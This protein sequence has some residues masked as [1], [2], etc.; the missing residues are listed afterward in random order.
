MTLPTST[1]L[2]LDPP[3]AYAAPLSTA[4]FKRRPEDFRVE[5]ILGFAA[6]GGEGHVLML[7]EKRG[8]DTLAVLR[9]LARSS[10]SSPRDWGFA[11][12]K[13]RWALTRQWYTAPARTQAAAAWREISEELSDGSGYR[14]IESW[15]HSRKLKRG[16]VKGNRFRI[17]LGGVTATAEAL[18]ERFAQIAQRGV[19]NYFGPQRFGHGLSNLAQVDAWVAGAPLPSEREAR[20][21][22]FSSAR[23]LLFNAVLAQRVCDQTWDRL[24]PGE[25]VNLDRSR[26]F[27][28]AEAVDDTLVD[29]LHR[30]DIHPTGPLF[31]RGESPAGEA[32]VA[33]VGVL[34]PYSAIR[35]ALLQAGLE[36]AR[37]PLRVV[38]RDCRWALEDQ[39]LT[40][41]FSLSAG[42]YATTVLAEVV[43]LVDG[44][45]P[46]P[47]EDGG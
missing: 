25:F 21:F 45:L 13:D 16:A 42:A 10:G 27:F 47:D 43:A 23:S 6:D 11:G 3:R 39:E 17:V 31:G 19:P 2:V 24:L 30:A 44:D 36:A 22:V 37:R 35:Q 41:E 4:A 8:L 34:E 14:V 1:R 29:R 28:V 46:E 20:A 9:R 40:V 26:S 32:G 5:E 15:P 18:A 33:E 7:V 38:P 12:L